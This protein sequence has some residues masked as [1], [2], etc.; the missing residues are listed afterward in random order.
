MTEMIAQIREHFESDEARLNGSVSKEL[1]NIRRN[2][3]DHF[4]EK[5]LPTRTNEEYKYTDLS[6][7]YLKFKDILPGEGGGKAPGATGIEGLEGNILV[8][9]NGKYMPDLSNIRDEHLTVM[10]L[11]D[12]LKDNE[13]AREHYGS[14]ATSDKDP[15]LA[16]NTA[17][18]HN[19]LFI[20]VPKNVQLNFPV[21]IHHH[22]D[23]TV[24]SLSYSRNLVVV[25]SGAEATVIEKF[26]SEG[27]AEF[28]SNL[29]TEIRVN[30]NASLEWF[31]IQAD[32]AQSYVIDQLYAYQERD[33]KLS[34]TTLTLDGNTIRNNVYIAID[35]ENCESHLY[36]L[37]AIDG[38]T[39]VDNH[40]AVDHLKPHCFSNE[41]YKGILDDKA[42]GVFNGKVYVRQDAQKT[43]AFQSNKNIL[44]SDTATV[45]TKPQL[46]IWADDVSCSHGC[47]TGQLDEE[48][49]FYLRTR[50]LSEKTARSL[51][52]YAFALEAIE[53]IGIEPLR[54]YAEKLI[55]DKLNYGAE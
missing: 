45:N 10:P 23:A 44:L 53:H 7:V 42:G 27:E 40:T 4:E 35:G 14:Y 26:E 22:T 15:L 38:T 33:S 43:N 18:V 8:T 17:F 6:K 32:G 52:L 39:H 28:L 29:V 20:H 48:A 9:V 31:K 46:E 16:L 49:L 25:E 51:L 24:K 47:T 13:A 37:Y 36:G 30:T 12:S 55:S 3:F 41:L 19:G 54:T 21:I 11:S 5:G 50:G 2:A 34:A 1:H